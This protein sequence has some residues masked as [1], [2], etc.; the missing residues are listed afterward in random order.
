MVE[1]SAGRLAG[2]AGAMEV[3]RGVRVVRA[4]TRCPGEALQRQDQREQQHE[5]HRAGAVGSHDI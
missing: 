4:A 1:R 3:R 2:V 5:N